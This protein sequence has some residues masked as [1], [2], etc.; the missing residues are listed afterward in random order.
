[1]A[2]GD[3]GRRRGRSSRLGAMPAKGLEAMQPGPVLKPEKKKKMEREM[4]KEECGA[5]AGRPDSV[6]G[7]WKVSG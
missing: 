2:L 4:E 5:V 3:N 6:S 1:M 7:G